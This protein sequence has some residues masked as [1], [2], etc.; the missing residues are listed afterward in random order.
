M[1][2]SERIEK[3]RD[4]LTGALNPTDLDIRDDSHLH[5][6][7]AGAKSGKGHFTIFI[8]SEQFNDQSRIAIHRLVYDAL[9]DMMETDIHALSIKKL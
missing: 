4:L 5:A 9:G 1:T 3:M 7:H 6:G 8:D 2:N